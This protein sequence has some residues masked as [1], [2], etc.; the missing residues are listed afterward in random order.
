[1]I[2]NVHSLG[3]LLKHN[4][5][6][7]SKILLFCDCKTVL[8]SIPYV[9]KS[10]ANLM[11]NCFPSVVDS[12]HLDS[13]VENSIMMMMTDESL[14]ASNHHHQKNSTTDDDDEEIKNIWELLF[15]R[16]CTTCR[17]KQNSFCSLLEKIEFNQV[18]IPDDY[19]D[20]HRE[21][22][23]FENLYKHL[24]RDWVLENA[25]KPND[26]LRSVAAN[27]SEIISM[28]D[29]VSL[30]REFIAEQE[31]YA[32]LDKH[33]KI[34]EGDIENLT[35]DLSLIEDTFKFTKFVQCI[36]VEDEDE[37]IVEDVIERRSMQVEGSFLNWN[38]DIV[39]M[40]FVLDFPYSEFNPEA[41]VDMDVFFNL[42]DMISLAAGEVNLPDLNVILGKDIGAAYPWILDTSGCKVESEEDMLHVLL[43]NYLITILIGAISMQVIPIKE[44]NDLTFSRTDDLLYFLKFGTIDIMSDCIPEVKPQV[45]TND[46]MDDS[47]ND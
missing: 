2:E 29:R 13:V 25:I 31:E 20:G 1:M 41:D 22:K 7:L 39:H 24:M 17:G 16:D 14:S 35:R 15:Y 10:W 18:F 11:Y 6:L 23:C 21:R 30:F 12:M 38:G 8:H 3:W 37:T 5:P 9:C 40:T 27:Y 28:K 26:A 43:N 44:Y 4:T 32:T 45:G 42:G 33:L 19:A 46:L 36:E 47:L 34:N